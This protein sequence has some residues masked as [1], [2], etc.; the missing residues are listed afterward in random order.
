M[1]VFPYI[2]LLLLLYNVIIANYLSFGLLQLK[3]YFIVEFVA[4]FLLSNFN[5]SYKNS[6]FIFLKSYKKY[7]RGEKMFLDNQE[8]KKYDA[9][10]CARKDPL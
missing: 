2:K 8:K 9:L 5:N 3:W 7:K 6:S 1:C 10:Y 4:S